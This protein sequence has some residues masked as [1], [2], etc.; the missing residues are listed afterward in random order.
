MVDQ[1]L[2]MLINQIRIDFKKNGGWKSKKNLFVIFLFLWGLYTLAKNY[3]WLPKK[4][5]KRKHVFI[6]GA[7]SGLG[8]EMAIRFAKLGA[9]VTL[10]DIFET[11]L[12][13]SHQLTRKAASSTGINYF[14]LDVSNRDQIREVA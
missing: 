14:V 4:S 2:R 7:G 6:T 10:T 3:G 11:G 8:R 5:V 13:E 1:F 12:K 9:K